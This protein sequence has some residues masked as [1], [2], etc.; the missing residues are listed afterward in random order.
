M[1]SNVEKEFGNSNSQDELAS[2]VKEAKGRYNLALAQVQKDCPLRE[3]CFSQDCLTRDYP[4][5]LPSQSSFEVY[6][7]LAAPK[8]RRW[9]ANW[10]R[11]CLLLT[12]MRLDFCRISGGGISIACMDF[13]R[14]LGFPG[15]GPWFAFL[16]WGLVWGWT[17]G[18]VVAVFPSHGI[19]RPRN[20]ADKTRMRARASVFL[21]E[22]RPV[23]T[24][25][26]EA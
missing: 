16:V 6:E 25:T 19:L 9:A 18:N 12:F 8:L 21:Q 24:A 26:E 20:K 1:F 15:K 13:D 5:P 2:S 10:A 17:W 11:L 22:G 14:T 7:G 4:L 23:E 3:L